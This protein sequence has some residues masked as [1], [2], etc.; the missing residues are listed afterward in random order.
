MLAQLANGSLIIERCNSLWSPRVQVLEC[1][2]AG[3]P[4][5]LADDLAEALSRAYSQHTLQQ[6][7]A[8]L[9]HNFDKLCLLGG[10]SD[11]SFGSGHLSRPVRVLVNGRAA[12]SFSGQSLGVEALLI[13]VCRQFFAQ[14]LPL[15][16][17]ERDLD[18]VLNLSTASSPGR[19]NS[20]PAQ[21]AG[22]RHRWFQPQSLHDLPERH[23]LCANDTS[24]GTGYAPRTAAERLTRGLTE[25]LSARPRAD[26]PPWLGTD[27]KVMAC[28]VDQRVDVVTCVPQI[29]D[30]VP[31][32]AAYLSNLEQLRRDT[33]Q[34]LAGEF[35]E[36]DVHIQFNT[37]DNPQTDELYLTA[38]GSSIESG[39][40]GVV[41][42]GNRANGLITP[43]RPMNVE[44]V[45]GKEEPDLPRRQALQ[46]PSPAYRRPPAQCVRRCGCRQPR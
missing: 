39:D 17:L 7:S 32:R 40:E 44:G 46:C 16:R 34:W 20:E 22:F 38:V 24:L 30:F 29:A 26:V 28:Q 35:P 3:H 27:V 45:S 42:R 6:C 18:I 25:Y 11:V 8:V 5:T 9:H 14:R 4:D 41:G 36:F 33:L 2:G 12:L 1:K 13:T 21:A 31:S 19:V 43:L 37:R 23:H 15:L 10:Q